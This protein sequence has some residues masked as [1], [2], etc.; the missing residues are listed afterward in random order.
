[1][2]I[3]YIFLI[4]F[5]AIGNFAF[6]QCNEVALESQQYF[7]NDFISDGQTYRALLF[8]DQVAEFTTLFFGG[9]TYRISANTG[10]DKGIVFNVLDQ[11]R[12][13]LF[14]S[15]DHEK[16]AYWD[17]AVESTLNCTIEAQLDPA[18]QNSGCAVILI[19]FKE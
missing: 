15:A 1:M 17:F 2:K 13:I 11:N 5:L 16:S 6:S 7:G 9:A 14:S 8:E 12:N 4:A 10:T 19:G 18:V 3:R